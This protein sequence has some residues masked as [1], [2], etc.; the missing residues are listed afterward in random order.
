MAHVLFIIKVRVDLILVCKPP[1]VKTF[2]D[3]TQPHITTQC[4]GS[5]GGTVEVQLPTKTSHDHRYVLKKNKVHITD[6]TRYSFNSDT[7][8]FMIMDINASD[9][10]T[11]SMEVLDK[12]E[13]QVK[14]T[15]FYL[16][17]QGE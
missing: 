4:F 6:N 5:L 13:A 17:L 15:K 16:S 1:G 2:C 7:K 3:A 8:I 12:Y 11:Y 9:G 14:N 10:G